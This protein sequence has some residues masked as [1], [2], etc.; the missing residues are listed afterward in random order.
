MN[1]YL[2]WEGHFSPGAN[3]LKVY[4]T[5]G[6]HK[7]IQRSLNQRLVKKNMKWA[8]TFWHDCRLQIRHMCTAHRECIGKSF[9]SFKLWI[10]N[11]FLRRM[12]QTFKCKVRK[13]SPKPGK[14]NICMKPFPIPW[15]PHFTLNYKVNS[16]RTRRKYNFWVE[17][18]RLSKQKSKGRNHKGK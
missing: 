4:L 18:G 7:L 15:H 17:W 12:F 9:H 10:L 5:A 2:E 6:L 13:H 11:Q 8:D 16:Q 3:N 14:W 1:W